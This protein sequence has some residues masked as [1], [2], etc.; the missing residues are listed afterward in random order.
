MDSTSNDTGKNVGLVVTVATT[1]AMGVVY[2]PIAAIGAALFYTGAVGAIAT[3]VGMVPVIARRC[4]GYQ[5]ISNLDDE[6]CV[7]LVPKCKILKEIWKV[8]GVGFQVPAYDG[9]EQPYGTN[10][11]PG[12]RVTSKF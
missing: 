5:S 11:I 10:D 7:E 2:T 12:T 4:H 6:S 9:I 3:A 8:P 1:A